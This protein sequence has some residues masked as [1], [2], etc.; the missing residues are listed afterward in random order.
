MRAESPETMR[1]DPR[2]AGARHTFPFFFSKRFF[3]LFTAAS[4]LVIPAYF[5]S[6]ASVALPLT[7]DIALILVA[8]ADA[9]TAPRFSGDRIKRRL[10]H[11]LAADAPATI[12]LEIFHDAV[13]PISLIITDDAP[14]PLHTTGLP[15]RLTLAPMTHARVEYTI[16]PLRRGT[17]SFGDISHWSRGRAG[18]AWRRGRVPASASVKALPAISLIKR[19]NLGLWLASAQGRR[20]SPLPRGELGGEFDGLRDYVPGDDVRL[21]HWATSARRGAPV[22]RVNRPERNQTVFLALDAGRM[23]TARVKGRTKFDFAVDA[24]LLLAHGALSLGDKVGLI[25][26]G[27][28]VLRIL[29]PAAN[30]ARFRDMLEAL[31][32]LEPELEEPRFR[33]LLPQV[34]T[35]L[36]RRSL[37]VVFTD[38]IDERVSQGLMR[39]LL[40]L[41]PRH[42]PLAAAMSDPDVARLADAMPH[43]PHD[44]YRQGV[45]SGLLDRRDALLASLSAAGVLVSDSSPDRLS[46]DTLNAYMRVKRRGLL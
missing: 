11:L 23:M 7:I 43:T 6:W 44:L 33:L 29:P 31:Y 26:F 34:G 32:D 40:S 3:I 36:K 19:A 10:P 35:L 42:L 18:L 15:I 24:A 39:C 45:A 30:P 13:R 17:V 16:A 38:L 12:T 27:R 14:D 8:I 28:E 4:V 37:I 2:S 22:V 41:M 46:A 21:I 20:T 5:R 9:A 25:A 1:V